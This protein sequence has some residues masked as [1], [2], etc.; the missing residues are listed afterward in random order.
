V[1]STTAMTYMTYTVSDISGCQYGYTV[2]KSQEDAQN[3][4][5][6]TNRYDLYN[7][8]SAVITMKDLDPNT[9]YYSTAFLLTGSKVYS[10]QTLHFKTAAQ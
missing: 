4:N 1:T 5:N 9:D 10:S 7:D 2:E 3:P 6:M 8:S